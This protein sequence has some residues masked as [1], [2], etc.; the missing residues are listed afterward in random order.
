MNTGFQSQETVG[1]PG[2]SPTVKPNGFILQTRNT[3]TNINKNR[4]RP[5]IRDAPYIHLF[6]D[7]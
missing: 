6:F 1:S 5:F 2:L 3:S 7:N 4:R